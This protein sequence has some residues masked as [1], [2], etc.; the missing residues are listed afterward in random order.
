M[1]LKHIFPNQ[2]SNGAAEYD[3]LFLACILISLFF[4]AVV[5]IPI[6][7]FSIRYRK[8]ANPDR[9]NPSAGSDLLECTWTI[10]PTIMGLGL[11]AWGG[12][13]YHKEQNPPPDAMEIHVIGKQW[14]WKV[15]HPEGAR[16][17]NEIHVPLGRPV[18]LLMTSQDVI[19][20]VFLPDF[21]IKQDVLPGKYTTEWFT[22]NKL[23]E[24]HLFCAEYCGTLHSKMGGRLI[25]M[26]PSEYERWLTSGPPQPTLAASGETLYRQLGCSGCHDQHGTVRAPPLTNLYGRSVALSTGETVLADERYIRDS[27]LLPA[28]QI[29]AG[30]EN[31]MPSFKGRISEEEILQIT[32]YLKSLT[33]KDTP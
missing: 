18:M 26:E 31:L 5:F 19:H 28:S 16:E 27:I 1:W 15:Q 14:M 8:S 24:Y 30:Y 4:I 6:I 9:S 29:V 10:I 13:L 17:I 32:A 33:A 11:F 12:I 21:R 23:G 7:A 25:V 20:D 22:P 2:A 3:W